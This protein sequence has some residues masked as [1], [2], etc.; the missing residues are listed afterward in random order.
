MLVKTENNRSFYSVC[1]TN[2][3]VRMEWGIATGL[4]PIQIYELGGSPIEVGLVFTVFSSIQVLSPLVWGAL[5]DSLGRRKVFIVVGMLG[6]PPIYML[7]A[8]QKTVLLLIL[9]RG[10]TAIFKGAV[11]TCSWALVS[12]LTTPNMV[13]RNMG[14]LGFS[15]LAGFG[16]GPVVGGLIADRY[17]FPTLW[18]SVALICFVGGLVFLVAGRDSRRLKRSRSEFSALRGIWK[19]SLVMKMLVLSV[20]YAVLLLGYS[21]LGPNL[22]VYLVKDLGY[23]KTMIGLISLAGTGI[24]TFIQPLF[25]YVSDRWSRRFV[26]IMGCVSLS[27][28]HL[29]L[30]WSGQV[31]WVVFSQALI[32]CHNAFFAASAAHVVN[33]VSISEKSRALSL[34]DSIGN[35]ARAVA[36]TGG[37]FVIAAADVQTALKIAAAFPVVTMLM[38]ILMVKS[39][40]H[41]EVGD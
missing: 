16:V 32:Q 33:M 8:D 24:A 30:L 2:F 14:V 6:L 22:N 3:L 21:F 41:H 19:R 15:E 27:L 35:V 12:D 5:S 7:M 18:Y 28:G 34:L 39:P 23:S 31:M 40:L 10:T 4:L 25:G 26:M 17:G 29:V 37:G 38:V 20:A 1:I 9:L 36:A 13:G 11:V